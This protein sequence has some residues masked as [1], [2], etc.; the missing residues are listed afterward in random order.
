[1]QQVVFRHVLVD[2]VAQALRARFGRKRQAALSHLLQSLG[3]VDGEA[4]DAQRRQGKAHALTL[5]AGKK[6]VDERREARVV[7]GRERRQGHLVVARRIEERARQRFERLGTALAHGAVCHARLTE[8]AAACAAAEKLQHEAVVHDAEVRHDGLFQKGR[9]IEILDDAPIDLRRSRLIEDAKPREHAPRIVLGRVKGRHINSRNP[10]S[11]AQETAPA[12]QATLLLPGNQGVAHLDDDFL[13]VAEHE[14]VE[15]VGDRLRIVYARA[16]ADDEGLLVRALRRMERQ[17]CE[18]KHVERVRDEKF[19]LQR[20]AKDVEGRNLLEGFERKERD[21]AAAHFL[22]HI[23][24]GRIN[25]FRRD[26]IAAVQNLIE[27]LQP[28]V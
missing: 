17:P 12:V 23:E 14:E 9:G 4:V 13:A 18:V 3:D 2:D 28:E 16:A 11:A 6:P 20:E 27:N 26:V 10:R 22:F 24:P 8:A 1:M 5:S 25:T 19:V 7:G 21:A 15:E